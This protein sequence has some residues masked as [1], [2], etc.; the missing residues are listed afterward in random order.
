MIIIFC[1]VIISRHKGVMKK[2]DIKGV[3]ATVS[4]VV[5]DRLFKFNQHLLKI[6]NFT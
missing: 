5:H 4:R 6:E 3:K 1:S 2:L